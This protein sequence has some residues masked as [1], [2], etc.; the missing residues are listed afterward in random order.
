MPA[1]FASLGPL[2]L[3]LFT[4]P[5]SWS[6]SEESALIEHKVA[7]GKPVLEWAGDELARIDCEIVLDELY[8]DPPAIAQKIETMRQSRTAWPLIRGDGQAMGDWA[9]KSIKHKVERADREGN[10]TRIQ[11][12][13]SLIEAPPAT[14]MTAT[15]RPVNLQPRPSAQRAAPPV[16]TEERTNPDGYTSSRI[17]RSP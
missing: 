13:L 11:L 15:H 12:T 14:A 5:S 17:V 16:K 8:C 7:E 4:A 1:H 6:R 10:A 9:I 2:D 3:K